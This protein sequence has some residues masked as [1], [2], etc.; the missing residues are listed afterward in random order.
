MLK[1]LLWPGLLMLIS[2]SAAVPAQTQTSAARPNGP[3]GQEI[4]PAKQALIKELVDVTDLKKNMESFMNAMFDQ[5][6][7]TLPDEI[8]ESLSGSMKDLTEAEQQKL[9]EEVAASIVKANQRF[10]EI[11]MRKVD[12]GQVVVDISAPLYSKYFT[13]AELQDLINFNKSATGQRMKEVTPQ[14]LAESMT[15]SEEVLGP[16]M[17]DIIKEI[18]SDESTKLQK[19]IATMVESHHSKGKPRSRSKRP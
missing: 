3:G 11:F 12:I 1:R 10:R 8:L 19:E 5:V 18:S 15:R 9:R 2:V 17:K 14:L 13:E 4:S 6:Q 7:K 16:V